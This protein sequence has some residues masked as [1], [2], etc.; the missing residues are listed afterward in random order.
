MIVFASN[1]QTSPLVQIW[2]VLCMAGGR[3]QE[4]DSW[5]PS[6]SLKLTARYTVYLPPPPSFLD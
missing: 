6:F 1:S 4:D 2:P 3:K 5:E